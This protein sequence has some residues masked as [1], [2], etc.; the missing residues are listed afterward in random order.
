MKKEFFSFLFEVKD[1]YIFKNSSATNSD[2]ISFEMVE[3][4]DWTEDIRLILIL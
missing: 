3:Y 2:S 4:V 1:A